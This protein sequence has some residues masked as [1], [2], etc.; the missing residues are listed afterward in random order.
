MRP[1]AALA[2][3]LLLLPL[4]TL[5]QGG[6][7]GGT[8]VSVPLA[9]GDSATVTGV[10]TLQHRGGQ[11]FLVL[12]SP[13]PYSLVHDHQSGEHAAK[14]IR[15]VAIHLAGR[16]GELTPL[17]GRTLTAK[18]RLKFQPASTSWNGA[19]LEAT[20]V[21]LPDGRQLHSKQ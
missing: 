6:T 20:V 21:V 17:A 14:V 18:G 9:N 12:Q 7:V 8:T 3:A 19:L 5:A 2:L 11:Q 4:P 15:D 13:T 10:L 16:D 1:T